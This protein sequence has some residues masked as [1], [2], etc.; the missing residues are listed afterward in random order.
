M[1]CMVLDRQAFPREKQCGGRI[2]AGTG[3][4]AD[5]LTRRGEDIKSHWHHCISANLRGRNRRKDRRIH[6]AYLLDSHNL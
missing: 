3:A 2:N 1:E 4:I 5:K 6:I